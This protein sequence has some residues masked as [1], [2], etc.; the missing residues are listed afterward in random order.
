MRRFLQSMVCFLCISAMCAS[1]S[2]DDKSKDQ[3]SYANKNFDFCI[4]FPANWTSSESYSRNGATLAPSNAKAFSLPPR[5]SVGARVDQPSQT[6]NGPQTL[7]ENIQSSID[8]L[9]EYGSALD[10]QVLKK[11][12]ITI[13]R[14]PAR[15]ITLKYRDSHSEDEWFVKDVNLIDHQNTVYF[16]EL[17]CHP[18]DAIA[19]ES[20]FDALVQSLRLQCRSRTRT[21]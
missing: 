6:G 3:K 7:D 20:I 21:E 5:I 15:A 8:S 18:K 2:A 13:Q 10:I 19:L 16:A 1:I 4:H 12:A 9:R 17:K 14:L 11:D